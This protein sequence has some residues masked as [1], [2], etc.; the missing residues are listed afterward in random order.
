MSQLRYCNLRPPQFF[1][2]LNYE[3]GTKS[4]VCHPI[5]FSLVIPFY[6]WY[7]CWE[8]CSVVLQ[9]INNLISSV[10]YMVSA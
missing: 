6:C 1:L 5:R 10:H 4:E 9:T 2:R 8:L 7:L 3:V